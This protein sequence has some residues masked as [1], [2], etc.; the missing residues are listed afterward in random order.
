MRQI[1]FPVLIYN[2]APDVCLGILADGGY[3]I[4]ERDPKRLTEVLTEYLRKQYRKNGEYP[5]LD[6]RDPKMKIV[7]T[8]VRPNY[9]T[10]GGAVFPVSKEVRIEMPIIYGENENGI[11]ECLLPLFGQVFYCRELRQLSTLARHFITSRLSRYAP[12]AVYRLLG[13]GIPKLEFI[14]LKINDNRKPERRKGNP[15]RN[16]PTLQNAAERLPMTKSARR[17]HS[18]LPPTAWELEEETA[19]LIR[20]ISEENSNVLVVGKHGTGKSAVLQQA[21]RKLVPTG[22]QHIG[23]KTFW[24][25]LPR[26][27]IS[28]SRYLGEWQKNVETLIAE[29]E[30][31]DGVLWITDITELMRIGGSVPETSVAAYLQSFIQAGK[32]RIL[33]EVTPRE[34]EGMQRLLSGFAENFRLVHLEE[35]SESKVFGIFRKVADY[36]RAT[37]KINLTDEALHTGYRLLKRYNPYESFP[38]KGIRFFSNVLETARRQEQ[39]TVTK[40]DIIQLFTRR[41]GLPEIFLRDELPLQKEELRAFF[42]ERIIGQPDA[43]ER[44]ANIIQVFKTGLNNPLKPIAVLLFAGPTGVG[45][46]NTAQALADYFFGN[47]REE[48]R[49]YNPLIRVD[50]SEYQSPTDLYRFFG[51]GDTPGEVV[52][53]VR[54]RPLSVLLLD[55]AEKASPVVYD[56]LL[57]VL[58]EG[59]MTDNFGRQTNFRNTIIIL[60]G[61]L[62]ASERQ[63]LGYTET[64]AAAV[65]YESALRTYFRPEFI[66]RLDAVVTFNALQADDI[67]KITKLELD[68]LSKREGLTARGIEIEFTSRLTQAI[69]AVGYDSKYGARPLQRAVDTRVMQPLAV[70]LTNNHATVKV[71]LTADWEAGKVI[72][73]AEKQ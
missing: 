47:N 2:L 6:L 56:A 19:D 25:I 53:E 15:Y 5:L 73:R 14:S 66:N 70:W 43:V 13:Y 10:A 11:I 3:E 50:M 41:T 67:E 44:L 32:V 35:M 59:I 62:G 28:G 57:R 48:D 4:T 72:F 58:D 61:N 21:I 71:K 34:L 24:R 22:K 9:T 31:A 69:A 37:H 16:F 63:P 64:N 54:N 42:T 7:G 26:K 46:T 29:A 68:K 18:M 36:A 52:N 39:D 1:N 20:K 65:K 8:E 55:E 23:G 45:K 27:F 49:Q 40:S 51:Y 38:G 17:R 30:A 12:E 60:T 33:G